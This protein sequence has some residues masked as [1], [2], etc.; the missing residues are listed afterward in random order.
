MAWP[1]HPQRQL[2]CKLVRGQGGIA[3]VCAGSSDRRRPGPLARGPRSAWLRHGETRI[4]VC[5]NMERL[6]ADR[7]DEMMRLVT[8]CECAGV[9]L[10]SHPKQSAFMS[11]KLD[12]ESERAWN[13]IQLCFRTLGEIGAALLGLP[14]RDRVVRGLI[15]CVF[16]Y[17]FGLETNRSL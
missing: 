9:T 15:G 3:H 8:A 10:R 1:D 2:P 4:C 16:R 13:T 17:V 12:S 5:G 7:S 14:V 11:E 6:N